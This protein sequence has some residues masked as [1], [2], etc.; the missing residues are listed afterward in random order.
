MYLIMGGLI[1]FF[2]SS[3]KS[4]P[5]FEVN[6]NSDG[7]YYFQLIAANGK[8]IATSEKFATKENCMQ[9]IELVK[10]SATSADII[11]WT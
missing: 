9:G 2:S 11:D 4:K 6:K 7:Q 8:I 3:A 1:M 5:K 10:S